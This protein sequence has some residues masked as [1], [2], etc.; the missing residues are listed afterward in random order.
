[1]NV[2]RK[3][4]L[5]AGLLADICYEY[6]LSHMVLGAETANYIEKAAIYDR[7]IKKI[8]AVLKEQ[9]MSIADVADIGEMTERAG[10][11]S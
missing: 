6:H 4:A 9:D 11:G 5:C 7:M 8:G 1:M 2:K 10:G 3:S